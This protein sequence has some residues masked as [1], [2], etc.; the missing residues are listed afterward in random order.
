M[1][2]TNEIKYINNLFSLVRNIREA[3]KQLK[4]KYNIDS[5]IKDYNTIMIKS[6]INESN[7]KDIIDTIYSIC[8]SDMVDIEFNK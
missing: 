2:Q 6:E 5:D 4:E 1:E 7:Q 8:P 3:Q